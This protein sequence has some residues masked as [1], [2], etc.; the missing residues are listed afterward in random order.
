M[1]ITKVM[2]LAAAGMALATVAQA[3]VDIKITGATAFRKDA[4][5]AIIKMFSGAPSQIMPP[6][7]TDLGKTT[8]ATFSGTMAAFPGKT[9]T[10][11]TSFS[12]SVEGVITLTGNTTMP[13]L[14]T[15]GT[16]NNLTCDMAFS[17][18]QQASTLFGTPVLD[19]AVVGVIPFVFAKS[20]PARNVV[21][22]DNVT[23][24]IFS[25]I[26]NLGYFPMFVLTGDATAANST[27]LVNIAGRNN[28][29]GTRLN[30]LAETGAGVLSAVMQRK[31][32]GTGGTAGTSFIPDPA[33]FSSGGDLVKVLNSTATSEYAIGYMGIGDALTLTYP[34]Y[35]AG[36]Q[37]LSYNGVQ[38]TMDNV[39]N[40]KYTL[41]GYEHMLNRTPLGSVQTTYRDALIAQIDLELANSTSAIQSGTMNVS[42]QADG[43]AVNP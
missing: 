41:W 15:D 26:I 19:D 7:V 36:G 6:G 13:F 31:L 38:Y 27:S 32:N 34:N 5:N 39:R 29:S 14:N 1:K 3:Q 40:G 18:V 8:M 37:W 33:G 9:V 22:L 12:G 20:V 2:T 25:S 28:L 11:R 24:Q 43:G 30:V 42:R 35:A 21:G 4:H 10:V 16:T 17:D 23:A